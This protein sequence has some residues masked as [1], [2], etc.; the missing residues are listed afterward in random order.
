[1]PK[2]C[3]ML[4]IVYGSCYS[5]LKLNFSLIFIMILNYIDIR[6]WLETSKAY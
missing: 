3:F 1:M 2:F 5:I 4:I 6:I